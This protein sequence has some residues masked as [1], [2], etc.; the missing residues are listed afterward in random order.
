[1]IKI[2]AANKTWTSPLF[3]LPVLSGHSSS[4]ITFNHG[5]SAIADN[6]GVYFPGDER[7]GNN[8]HQRYRQQDYRTTD[9]VGYALR[10]QTLNSS[11]ITFF[12]IF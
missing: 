6:V 11:E 8:A 5:R 2:S 4:L 12:R 10:T 7:D 9:T 1:M 3:T